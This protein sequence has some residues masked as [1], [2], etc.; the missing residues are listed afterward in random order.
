MVNILI[1]QAKLFIVLFNSAPW[2]VFLFLFHFSMKE[3]RNAWMKQ[4]DEKGRFRTFSP[5]FRPKML[6]PFHLNWIEWKDEEN[7]DEMLHYVNLDTGEKL[8][9]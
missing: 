6:F 3:N 5:E 4:I 2:T 8:Q 1:R 9:F 7:G